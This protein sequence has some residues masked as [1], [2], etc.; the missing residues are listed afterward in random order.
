MN[1][2]LD[3]TVGPILKVYADRAGVVLTNADGD[4]PGVEMN[5]FRYVKGIGVKPVLCGNIKGLRILI[6]ILQHRKA[7][8]R[9]GDRIQRWSRRL[10]TE[11][12][13]HLNRLLWPMPQE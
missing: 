9:N 8:Q 1:A 2:E 11:Q 12:K 3:S 7:L 4:Q 5:L 6:A 10:Q 13:F